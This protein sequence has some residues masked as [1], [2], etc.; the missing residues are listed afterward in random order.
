[1]YIYIYIHGNRF[2]QACFNGHL[3]KAFKSTAID[4]K[5]NNL[6]ADIAFTFVYAF[7]IN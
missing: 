5:P 3:N 4:T 7:G 2:R 1:M 6:S